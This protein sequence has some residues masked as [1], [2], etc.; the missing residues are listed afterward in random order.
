M[1]P[2]MKLSVSHYTVGFHLGMGIT[3]FYSRQWLG[4]HVCEMTNPENLLCQL[5]QDLIRHTTQSGLVV[6]IINQRSLRQ[7]QQATFGLFV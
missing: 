1:S 6:I 3:F 2:L 4:G 5:L 7:A